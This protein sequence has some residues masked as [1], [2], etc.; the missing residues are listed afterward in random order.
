MT[1]HFRVEFDREEDGRWI[2]EVLELP[3]VVAYGDSKQEA[4]ANVVAIARIIALRQ[5]NLPGQATLKIV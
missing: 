3:R 1:E 5:A 4:L 2:T